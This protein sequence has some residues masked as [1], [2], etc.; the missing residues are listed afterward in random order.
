[1]RS[2]AESSQKQFKFKSDLRETKTALL[3]C[4]PLTVNHLLHCVWA[5]LITPGFLHFPL[6][7]VLSLRS[8][9]PLGPQDLND[10]LKKQ[11]GRLCI[12]FFSPLWKTIIDPKDA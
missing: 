7:R 3:T 12:S 5:H 2:Q 10:S 1:M 9:T 8:R 4:S 11:R 6:K